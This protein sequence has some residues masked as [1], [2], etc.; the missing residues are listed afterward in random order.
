MYI[1][2]QFAVRQQVHCVAIRLIVLLNESFLSSGKKIMLVIS[3]MEKDI[4]YERGKSVTFVIRKRRMVYKKG[5]RTENPFEKNN[6][7]SA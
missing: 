3:C 7:M 4:Q 6:Q 5:K 2:V 1:S